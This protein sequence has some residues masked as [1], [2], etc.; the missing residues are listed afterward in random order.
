M[1]RTIRTDPKTR[2]QL[3]DGADH[4]NYYK[5]ESKPARKQCARQLRHATELALHG[6]DPD[7]DT[8]PVPVGTCG[9]N[10]H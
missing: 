10:T 3:R 9:Y 8:L 6:F 2:D 7:A 5:K 4:S 1:A